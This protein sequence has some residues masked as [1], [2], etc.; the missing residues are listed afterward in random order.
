MYLYALLTVLLWSSVATAFKITLRI[1]T[2]IEM[3]FLSTLFSTF[4]L[5]S[6]IIATGNAKTFWRLLERTFKWGLIL[7][8]LNPYLYYIVL[9]AAYDKLP[10]QI[11]QGLNYTWAITVTL[12]SY[13][14]LK[15][16]NSLIHWFGLVIAFVGV[17]FIISSESELNISY[18]RTG[19]ILALASSIIWSIYW[20]LN[21]KEN[22]PP[23]L[24]LTRNFLLSI[25][26]SLVTVILTTKTSLN[27]Y[28]TTEAI[29]GCFFIG[30][31]EMGLAFFFWLKA[32]QRAKQIS[33]IV[34]LSY[35]SPVLSLAWIYFILQ[36]KLS[37]A[38]VIGLLFI[39]GG[40]M[41]SLI[42]FQRRRH[43]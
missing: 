29:A 10:A 3:V 37:R 13:L 6:I 42:K 26:F 33:H 22:A 25:P 32:I 20:I 23:L 21:K 34:P 8:F 14:I 2:P 7:G 1:I 30:I 15:E 40:I 24:A 43:Q 18:D 12:L 39:I 31:A 5:F 41:I 36:E 27:F 38:A 17:L 16:K 9:F 11:A 28:Q 35:L 4:I 19:I